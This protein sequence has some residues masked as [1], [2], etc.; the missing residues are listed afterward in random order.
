MSLLGKKWII[1]NNNPHKNVLEKVLENRGYDELKELDHLHDP[2]M[3]KGMEIAV[4]RLDSAIKNKERII[5]F[6]DYDVDGISGTA[7]LVSVLKKLNANVSYRLPNRTSDGYGLSEKFIDEFIE[8]KINLIITVDCGVSCT[9]E[10]DKAKK[11]GIDV[12]ITDHHT[13]PQN[14]PRSV[15]CILHPKLE[16]SEYPYRELTGAGVA[17]KLAEALIYTYFK[18]TD[19]SYLNEL[20]NLASLGTIA[21]LGPLNGE[22]RLIVKKGLENL[23][24]TKSKGL[25]KIIDLS[26]N[27]ERDTLDSYTIGF[28]IAPR[29]NAAGR[30]GDPYIALSLLLEDEDENKI[31]ILG[32]KLDDLNKQRQDMT[33]NA[34][35]E[36]EEHIPCHTELISSRKGGSESKPY[37]LIAENSGWHVGILGLVAG[38]LTEKYGL[39]SIIMQDL[40]ET[41][42]GSARSP[43]VF[44]ITEALNVCSEFLINFGGHSQ[45]AGFTIKKENL[46]E[47]K[48]AILL[49][50][51]SQLKKLDLKPILEIDC[52][53]T[54]R[55]IN[56]NLLDE[57]E[58]LAPFGIGNEKPKFLVNGVTPFFINTVGHNNNHLKLTAKIGDKDISAI[59]FQMGSFSDEVRKHKK[60]DM[61]CHLEKN[62]WNNRE[63][64]NLHVLDI[65][66]SREE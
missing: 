45:A 12:I 38:K 26:L 25:K 37:I 21:D 40:G 16:D 43:K 64:L 44:N 27:K 49:Y 13:I 41:L 2:F 52:E 4:K 33:E 65:R 5:V 1:K 47:F 62:T 48:K 42:V 29:I 23:M 20:I 18:K 53:L 14:I 55:D 61:V 54:S 63:Y 66:V 56:T 15:V 34:M 50:A 58:R 60:I 59:G 24:N 8:K 51:E 36:A 22:N 35:I 19:Y 28:R 32:N 10:I 7:I 11:H 9:N 31:N 46:H 30:I 39:P 6:G 57:I 3:F 17:L